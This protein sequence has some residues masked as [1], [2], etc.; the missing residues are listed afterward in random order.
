MENITSPMPAKRAL[1]AL[2]QPAPAADIDQ[3]KRISQK[4]RAAIDAMVAGGEIKTIADAARHVGLAR[5]T[6]SRSLGIPHIAEHLRQKV[7]RH[8]AIH[9]ARAGA[10]KVDLLDSDNAMARD[11]ASIFVLGLAGIQPATTPSVSL[12]IEV[13]AG[14]V[15]DLSDDPAPMKTI[16]HV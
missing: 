12:N 7:I 11:R 6:L 14:Y 1:A 16:P 4:V 5:E 3:T 15:I 13:K 10:T 2:D 9:A 8:L